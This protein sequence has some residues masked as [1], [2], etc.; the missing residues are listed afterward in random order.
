MAGR[1]RGR[2]VRLRG[3]CDVLSGLPLR[4]V[5]IHTEI[6]PE[7]APGLAAMRPHAPEATAAGSGT[8]GEP[9]AV[10]AEPGGT[11]GAGGHGHG[12]GGG[13]AAVES[14]LSDEES[15]MV[16]QLQAAA[17]ACHSQAPFVC[18]FSVPAWCIP[19]QSQKRR[20]RAIGP[21]PAVIGG[22][23]TIRHSSCLVPMN[24]L[25]TVMDY[26]NPQYF[27]SPPLLPKASSCEPSPTVIQRQCN[28]S[29]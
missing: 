11:H 22:L 4:A 25:Q 7:A 5:A 2:A 29:R 27:V 17:G 24:E 12:C 26:C 14:R 18:N 3:L 1:A 10:T 15:R 13:V 28:N 23:Y 9:V 20:D 8:S 16:E 21:D 19:A 6:L